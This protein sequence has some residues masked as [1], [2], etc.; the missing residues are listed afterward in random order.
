MRKTFLVEGIDCANCAAKLERKIQKSKLVNEVS[1]NFMTQKMK[2][3]CEDSA[4]DGVK[5]ICANFE[6]GVTLTEL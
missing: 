1:I 2:L 3:D 4:L 5:E 6:E